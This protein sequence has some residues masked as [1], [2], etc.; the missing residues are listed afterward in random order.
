MVT[1]PLDDE[2]SGKTPIELLNERDQRDAKTHQDAYAESQKEYWRLDRLATRFH[3]AHVTVTICHCL[4][5]LC[6]AAVLANTLLSML[7]TAMELSERAIADLLLIIGVGVIVLWLLWDAFS[8]IL[9]PSASCLVTWIAMV[10]TVLWWR[11]IDLF[12][13]GWVLA[14]CIT[15]AHLLILSYVRRRYRRIV[16]CKAKKGS[17]GGAVFLIV[18]DTLLLCPLV[19]FMLVM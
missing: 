3:R 11:Y 7:L 8:K 1:Y 13:S 9:A 19:I 5:L 16:T 14:A 15:L 12:E 10:L 6:S 18:L 2:K 17:L 4:L